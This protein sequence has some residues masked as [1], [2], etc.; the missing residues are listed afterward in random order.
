MATRTQSILV[1]CREEHKRIIAGSNLAS[2]HSKAICIMG[3][4][5]ADG[6][7]LA[8]NTSL[9]ALYKINTF[10]KLLKKSK[11]K[12]F[13]LK[14]DNNNKKNSSFHFIFSPALAKRKGIRRAGFD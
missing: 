14:N 5:L 2:L 4:M 12:N 7:Q 10:I 3:L 9:K 1:S 6:K 8:K 11:K 13:I